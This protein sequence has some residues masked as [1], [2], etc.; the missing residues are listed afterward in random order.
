MASPTKSEDRSASRVDDLRSKQ[1]I[2]VERR[3][4]PHSLFRRNGYPEWQF[5]ARVLGEVAGQGEGLKKFGSRP[6]NREKKADE[7][8]RQLLGRIGRDAL[9]DLQGLLGIEARS[10]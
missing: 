8:L 5:S 2:T 7:S 3:V 6:A 1:S 4:R 9:A 10:D